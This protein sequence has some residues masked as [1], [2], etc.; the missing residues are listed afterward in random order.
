VEDRL[1]TDPSIDILVNAAG[2]TMRS[3]V[4]GTPLE[5]MDSLIELNVVAL[6]HLSSVAAD[7]FVK[8]RLGTIVN[9]SSGVVA[10]PEKYRGIYGATKAYVLNFS[11]SLSAEVQANGVQVQVVVPHAT[12]TE[13]FQRA[14][15]DIGSFESASIMEPEDLVDAALTGLDRG[16]VVTIPSLPDAGIWDAL[17]SARMRLGAHLAHGQPADRYRSNE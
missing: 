17:T 1:R 12:R 7:S 4:V 6:T 13:I 14:G 9:L 2:A 10:T 5:A 15:K 16:E 11:I 3:A 8:R